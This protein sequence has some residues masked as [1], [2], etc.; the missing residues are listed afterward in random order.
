M[1]SDIPISRAWL[2]S[3][4]QIVLDSDNPLE[5]PFTDSLLFAGASASKVEMQ[6][7]ARESGYHTATKRVEGI[8]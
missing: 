3:I 7:E 8:P 4:L 5:S 6:Q 2:E 1:Q